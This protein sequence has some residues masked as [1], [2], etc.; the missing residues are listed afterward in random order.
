LCCF[1]LLFTVLI[2]SL[3][4]FCHCVVLS[5]C[6][7]LFD[8]FVGIFWPLCCFVLR[9][10]VFDYSFGI[11]KLLWQIRTKRNSIK[12]NATYDGA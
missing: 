12:T 10:M 1:V 5:F 9:I 11:F 4:S 3:V 7:R 2:T 6:L 8:Y